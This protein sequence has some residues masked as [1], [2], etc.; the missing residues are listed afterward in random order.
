MIQMITNIIRVT[1]KID[2]QHQAVTP[3]QDAPLPAGGRPR[4][5]VEKLM[6]GRR[7]VILLHGGED[8]VLRI[9]SKGKLILTK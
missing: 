4:F 3:H 8:Y 1:M 9:T 7:E 5:E 2:E 6:A